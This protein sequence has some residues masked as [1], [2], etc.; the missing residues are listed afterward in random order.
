MWITNHQSPITR[1][2]RSSWKTGGQFQLGSLASSEEPKHFGF[3]IFYCWIHWKK[4]KKKK[5]KDPPLQKK[6]KN[7]LRLINCICPFAQKTSLTWMWISVP[8]SC[9]YILNSDVQGFFFFMDELFFLIALT[10]S[11][12]Y[13]EK[14]FLPNACFPFSPKITR[15]RT[16]YHLLRRELPFVSPLFFFS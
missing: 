15:W 13:F 7:N 16:S 2:L 8:F 3:W 1:N 14:K 10:F 11:N 5:K 4:K 9:E 12:I 6:K